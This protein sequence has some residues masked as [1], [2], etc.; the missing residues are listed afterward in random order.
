MTDLELE[1]MRQIALRRYHTDPAFRMQVRVAARTLEDMH[2][3]P[4]SDLGMERQQC[5][6]AAIVSVH[7]AQLVQQEASRAPATPTWLQRFL[8][9]QE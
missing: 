6:G 5:L 9:E 8:E 7:V 2:V 3:L 4:N 1:G